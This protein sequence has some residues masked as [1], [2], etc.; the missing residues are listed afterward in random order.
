ML[1]NGIAEMDLFIFVLL[2]VTF[3]SAHERKAQGESFYITKIRFV[4]CNP[5]P[6]KKKL[7]SFQMTVCHSICVHNWQINSLNRLCWSVLHRRYAS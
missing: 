7:F 1:M 2:N 4:E 5:Y 6:E 3:I